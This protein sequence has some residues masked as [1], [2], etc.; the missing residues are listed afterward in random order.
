MHRT[1]RAKQRDGQRRRDQHQR[2]D[3]APETFTVRS[4]D[5][6]PAAT[7]A[8]HERGGSCCG[9]CGRPTTTRLR[10]IP[11]CSAR[12]KVASRYHVMKTTCIT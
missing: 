9:A 4:K 11:M 6:L 10:L 8:E 7:I 5:L 2:S 12:D 1:R 3:R